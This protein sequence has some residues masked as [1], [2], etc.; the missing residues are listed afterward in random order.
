MSL[1]DDIPEGAVVGLDTAPIIYFLERHPDYGPLVRPLFEARIEAGTNTAVTSTIS[2]AEV[3]V[4]PLSTG[5]NDLIAAYRDLLT[6]SS[7][8]SLVNVT[9]AVAER[10]ADL[11]A[12]YNLRLPDACQVASALEA[13]TPLLVTNDT[14]LRRVTE[15]KILVL[16]DYLP[17]VPP[18]PSPGSA[19]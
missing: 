17:A 3:L 5:R 16:E 15:L 2:L 13:Q 14:R 10:A 4:K 18:A 12:R 6:N 7:R 11:R 9:P 1:L 8:L 19:P